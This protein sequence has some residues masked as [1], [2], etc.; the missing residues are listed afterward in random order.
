M[1][2]SRTSAVL[3]LCGHIA[4]CLTLAGLF[5]WAPASVAEA[6]P[7]PLPGNDRSNDVQFLDHLLPVIRRAHPGDL[8]DAHGPTYGPSGD[9]HYHLKWITPEG[10]VYWFDADARNG[11]VQRTSPG[12]DSFDDR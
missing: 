3:G 8:S 4:L 2:T 10:G 12:R 6:P 11:Q 5:F 1:P 9:P 7:R